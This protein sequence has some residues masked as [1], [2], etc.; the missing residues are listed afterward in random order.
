MHKASM[1][2]L[3]TYEETVQ[4][5]QQ[6]RARMVSIRAS[7]THEESV[8]RLE[9]N[10]KESSVTLEAAVTTFQSKVKLGPDFVCTCCHRMMYNKVLLSAREQSTPKLELR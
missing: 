10:M 2:T 7:E 9:Q 8:R 3:E 1:R 4:T 6:N 5:L